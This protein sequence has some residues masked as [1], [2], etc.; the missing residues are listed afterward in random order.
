MEYMDMTDDD[1]VEL[2]SETTVALRKSDREYAA[3]S[4]RKKEL[5]SRF[6]LIEPLIE[7]RVAPGLSEDER[8]GLAEHAAVSF[9][10]E[11]RERRALYLAGHSDCFAYLKRIGAL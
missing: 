3:L 9:A 11:Q 2:D 1:F 10:M 7:G 8:A 5:E 4:T 6:P